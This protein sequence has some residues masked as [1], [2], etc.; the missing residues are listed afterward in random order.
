MKAVITIGVLL[1]SF[2]TCSAENSSPDNS[3]LETFAVDGQTVACRE[4][5]VRFRFRGHTVV[6][7]PTSGGFVV[8]GTFDRKASGW[9]NRENVDVDFVCGDYVLNLQ[10]Y[11]GLV[12][13]GSWKFG[14]EYPPHWIEFE[15]IKRDSTKGTWLSYLESE[16][17][18]CDPGVVTYLYHTDPPASVPARLEQEQLRASGGRARD[19]AYGLAVFGIR[20]EQ[21]RDYLLQLLNTCLSRS[22]ES[23]EDDICDG[24][25]L[26]YVTNLYW[27]GDADLL[28]PLLKIAD[29]RKD[30]LHDVG[31]FYADV[32]DGRPAAIPDNMKNLPVDKQRMICHLAGV[33]LWHDGPKLERVSEHLRSV[34]GEVA[35]R[36]LKEAAMAAKHD[37]SPAAESN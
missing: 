22:K 12:A 23:S 27:R 21:N 33:E 7:E 18:G 9:S 2:V 32:L 25:L 24:T 16:C 6:P 1:A 30:V 15:S 31:I 4:T 17:N 35:D 20:Y 13:P 8:P 3:V 36:C 37:S 5:L 28:E 10:I 29:P 34:G 11:A 19:I 26:D 14:I